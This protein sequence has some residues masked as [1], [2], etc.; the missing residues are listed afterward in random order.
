MND[1]DEIP[2]KNSNKFNIED[3]PLNKIDDIPINI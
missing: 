1:Y 3:K 2:L